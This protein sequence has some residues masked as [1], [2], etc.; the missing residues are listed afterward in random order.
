M[1]TYWYTWDHSCPAWTRNLKLILSRDWREERVFSSHQSTLSTCLPDFHSPWNGFPCCRL[2]FLHQINTFGYTQFRGIQ[3]C[4]NYNITKKAWSG[5][6]NCDLLATLEPFSVISKRIS[7]RHG[8]LCLDTRGTL[9]GAP[10]QAPATHPAPRVLPAAQW[11][12]A[13]AAA[14]PRDG[15]CPLGQP[16]ARPGGHSAPGRRGNEARQI[17][18]LH[19]AGV[20]RCEFQV[21]DDPWD[22]INR[23][24]VLN[25][26]SLWW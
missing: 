12:R 25:V 3:S 8:D 20:P 7:R 2:L 18:N 13:P 15:C 4:I 26:N 21:L 19:L 17:G 10:G 1:V 23:N 14:D 22:F 11:R 5:L 9:P 6:S 24:V 16:D